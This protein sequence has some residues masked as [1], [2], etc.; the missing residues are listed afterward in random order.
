MMG[1]RGLPAAA[2][3]WHEL[4]RASGALQQVSSVKRFEIALVQKTG[5]ADSFRLYSRRL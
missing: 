2:G 3:G 4:A 5:F 1:G